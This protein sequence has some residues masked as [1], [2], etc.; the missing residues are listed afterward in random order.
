GVGAIATID[1][2]KRPHA[3]D[4]LIDHRCKY[5]IA[6]ESDAD[7]PEDLDRH[8]HAGDAALHVDRPT[9]SHEAF[10]YYRREGIAHPVFGRARRHDVDM[11]RQHDG[12]TAALAL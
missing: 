12:A 6:R 3:A 9:T 5:D 10:G 4:L 8:Q 11:A 1:H 2:G 7:L